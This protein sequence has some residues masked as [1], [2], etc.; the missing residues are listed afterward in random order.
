MNTIP[1]LASLVLGAA[2]VV[3]PACAVAA[4][5]HTDRSANLEKG[6]VVECTSG[7]KRLEAF[8]SMYENSRYANVLQVVVGDPDQGLG[9]SVEDPAGFVDGRAAFGQVEVGGEVAT[10]SGSVERTGAPS[11]VHEELTD[12]GQLIVTRGWH[13]DLR[14]DLSLRYGDVSVPLTCDTAFAYHLHVQKTPVG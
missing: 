11:R 2:A 7:A 8:V 10:V 9:S 3:V 6:L 13:R 5:P 14:A 4:P 1:R 12:A